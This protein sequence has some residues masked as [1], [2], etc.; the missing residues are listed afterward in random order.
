MYTMSKTTLFITH[1][2][3]RQQS[4]KVG[5]VQCTKG[6]CVLLFDTTSVGVVD[7]NEPFQ[8]IPMGPLCQNYNDSAYDVILYGG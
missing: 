4:T 2:K 3:C 7:Q 5:G 6:T 8:E 1:K